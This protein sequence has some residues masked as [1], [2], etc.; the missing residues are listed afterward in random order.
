MKKFLG[1]LGFLFIIASGVGFGF[2]PTETF[3]QIPICAIGIVLG[4]V[5][6]VLGLVMWSSEDKWR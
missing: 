4:V 5:L 6:F 2:K 3:N 1:I